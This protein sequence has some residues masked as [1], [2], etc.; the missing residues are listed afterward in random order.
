MENKNAALV[1]K[2][3]AAGD[4]ASEWKEMTLQDA[5]DMLLDMRFCVE[6]DF[7]APKNLRKRYASVRRSL[8]SIVFKNLPQ[9]D[10]DGLTDGRFTV[11]GK[12]PDD[13]FSAL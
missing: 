8:W 12:E 7:D 5:V 10:F 13:S 1:C 9:L 4:P 2:T 3:G 6:F 11:I